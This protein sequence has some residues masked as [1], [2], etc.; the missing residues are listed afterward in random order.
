MG[1]FTTYV[2][3][4][5]LVNVTTKVAGKVTDYGVKRIIERRAD[6]FFNEAR[7]KKDFQQ[8]FMNHDLQRAV[9]SSYY[10]SI[11]KI[12][13]DCLEISTQQAGDDKEDILLLNEAVKSIKTEIGKKLDALKL[14]PN[15]ELP[16]TDYDDIKELIFHVDNLNDQ[17]KKRINEELVRNALEFELPTILYKKLLEE[18]LFKYICSFFSLELKENEK[19]Y[20]IFTAQSQA[21]SEIIL[22]QINFAVINLVDATLETREDVKRLIELS[23]EMYSLLTNGKSLESTQFR[24]TNAIHLENLEHLS[25]SISEVA[26][27]MFSSHSRLKNFLQKMELLEQGNISEDMEEKLHKYGEV[28]DEK[29]KTWTPENPNRLAELVEIAFENP[30]VEYRMEIVEKDFPSE[31]D[32]LLFKDWT[33]KLSDANKGY[34][35]QVKHGFGVRMNMNSIVLRLEKLSEELQKSGGTPYSNTFY[36]IKNNFN[37]IQPLGE[38]N[39]KALSDLAEELEEMAVTLKDYDENIIKALKRVLSEL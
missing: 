1:L 17:N 6:E 35:L 31:L 13:E 23:L 32:Q 21:K 15:P 18:H 34:S 7:K 10:K 12:G 38:Y 39:T 8:R 28:W 33:E 5:T 26:T 24:I 25:N 29:E 3:G 30:I 14:D 19:V 20:R 27:S 4:V 2:A 36:R 11:I 22:N 16:I 37:G 9:V